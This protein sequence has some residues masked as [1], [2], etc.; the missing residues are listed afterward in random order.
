MRRN[1]IASNAADA[2]QLLYQSLHGNA[3]TQ[4]RKRRLALPSYSL[5]L[6]PVDGTPF[7]KRWLR[8]D[9]N[10]L[11]TCYDVFL[12]YY[13]CCLNK[14]LKRNGKIP[15]NH[16]VRLRIGPSLAFLNNQSRNINK[17][18]VVWLQKVANPMK[19]E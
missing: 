16:I 7:T 2:P 4:V 15:A 14:E 1:P 3:T 5:H 9:N 18:T 17:S 12:V 13:R 8:D 6:V 11:R 10:D 19:K